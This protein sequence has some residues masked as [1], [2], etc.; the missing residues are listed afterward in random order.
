MNT[1]IRGL[2]LQPWINLSQLER[3]AGIPRGSLWLWLHDRRPL[4]DDKLD[5]VRKILSALNDLDLKQ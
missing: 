3:S 2:L 5:K 1:Q 4:S